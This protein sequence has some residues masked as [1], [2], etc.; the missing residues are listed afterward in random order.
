MDYIVLHRAANGCDINK[1]ILVRKTDKIL[2][3]GTLSLLLRGKMFCYVRGLLN[4]PPLLNP[5][6]LQGV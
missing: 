4:L 6:L 3:I 1:N 5:E 2:L